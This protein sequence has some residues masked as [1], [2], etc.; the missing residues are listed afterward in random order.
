MI[1]LAAL[2]CAC[3][4]L[5]PRIVAERDR[6]NLGTIGVTVAR[7]GP[8]VRIR[9]PGQRGG[10]AG[11][12]IGGLGAA[13]ATIG[14]C[15]N[16]L[17]ILTCPSM[18]ATAAALGATAGGVLGHQIDSRI[19]GS[20]IAA[21]APDD[22]DGPQMQTALRDWT[23]RHVRTVS[24]REYVAVDDHA[25]RNRSERPDY[26]ALAQRGIDTALELSLLEL[27]MEGRPKQGLLLAM[28]SRVRIV[29]TE[30]GAIMGEGVVRY[31]SEAQPYERWTD[32]E[33]QLFRRALESGFQH[34]AEIIARETATAPAG[35]AARR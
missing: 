8:D 29:S 34:V 18:L 28:A 19:T 3:A 27:T 22:L 9:G 26:R 14:A 7:Y 4:P 31:R 23:L 20:D 6:E 5:Q 17:A 16:P 15:L 33:A 24:S 25:P 13:A 12:L 2:Q 30:N 35:T 11:I 1:L 21:A 32:R 10:K